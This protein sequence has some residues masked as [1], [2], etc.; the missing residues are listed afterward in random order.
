M[1]WFAWIAIVAILVW[2]GIS[3]YGMASGK[4]LPWSEGGDPKDIEALKKRLEALESGQAKP[5][6]ERRIDRLEA[7]VE[8]RE[9][10]DSAH[11]DW[12]RHARELGLGDGSGNGSGGGAS[13]PAG[14]RA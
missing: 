8:K 5:E 10:R 9:L 11:D 13:G 2:G 14:P 1:P 3:I 6:L 4:P 12:E 7:R